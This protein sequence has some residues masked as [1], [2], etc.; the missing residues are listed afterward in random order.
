[1]FVTCFGITDK[2][3]S[4]FMQMVEL[5]LFMCILILI[6]TSF[7]LL[8]IDDIDITVDTEFSSS[9]RWNANNIH[10]GLAL[11]RSVWLI[12]IIFGILNFPLSFPGST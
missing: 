7:E 3:S 5:S 9:L 11:I 8:Y 4:I 2:C 12:N 6:E 1:M 10:P